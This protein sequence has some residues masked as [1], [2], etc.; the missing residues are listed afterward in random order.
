MNSSIVERIKKLL[1]LANSDNANE[2]DLALAK[3]HALATEHQIDLALVSVA[4]SAPE[5][6]IKEQGGIQFRRAPVQLKFVNWI[7]EKHFR[8]EIVLSWTRFNGVKTST[9]V[10]VG[11]KSDVELA[12]WMHSYLLEEFSRRWKS[13]K[14]QTGHG[15]GLRNTYYLGLYNGL[16]SKLQEAREA[17]EAAKL[18]APNAPLPGIDQAP[19]PDSRRRYEVALVDESKK[20][21]SALSNFFPKLRTLRSS[22]IV[23]KN[24]GVSSDGFAA[25]RSI[26]L[27]RPLA[28]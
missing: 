7:L 27:N 1:S 12:R 11:R 23:N 18:D 9:V 2:R 14:A 5:P 13:Y 10:F 24:G 22:S 28:A 20:L 16:N 8:V 26:N 19:S 15:E 3:A 6:F 17:A 4:E 21:Q 25:G